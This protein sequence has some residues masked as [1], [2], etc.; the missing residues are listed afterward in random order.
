[1]ATLNWPSGREF[2]PRE[3]SFGVSVPKSRFG[4]F[5][6]GQVQSVSHLAERLLATLTLPP[7]D[8]A[9]GARREA[10]FMEVMDRG[11]W[12]RLGHA[13][14]PEPLGSL[15]GTPT[16]AA[17]APRGATS[18][19]VATTAGATLLPGD[20]L[21][22]ASGQLLLTAY[23][24]AVADGG[25]LMA[26]PLVLP[27]RQVLGLGTGLVWERPTATFEL[28]GTSVELAYGRGAWQRE[29]Q[30]SFREAY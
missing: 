4:A 24:G 27:L 30:L 15:R 6:S 8:A 26:V 20:P 14:R 12:L 17:A 23:Q 1:M 19:Q 9:A 5:F 25:G 18:I 2:E 13:Q 29:L 11:H 22:G 28:A 21:G 7:C 10:F 3:F 16:L